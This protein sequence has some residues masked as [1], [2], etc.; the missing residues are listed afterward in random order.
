MIPRAL[1][2]AMA[3]AMLLLC[4]P[5]AARAD[6]NARAG[7]KVYD[8]H[9]LVCHAVEPEY[10]KEGP[11]LAGVFGRRAGKAPFF[12]SYKAL[13]GSTIVWDA[14]T[15]DA[16]LADPRGLV[17]GK[18]TGMTFRLEDAQARAD[19]IAYLKGL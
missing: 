7:Q 17:G 10:H 9:C 3:G 4:L 8:Q 6:G 5:P 18:D 1:F 13:K 19:V 12:T 16:W 14:Q 11:S 2:T 15:L